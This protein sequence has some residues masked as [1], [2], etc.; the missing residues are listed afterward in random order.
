MKTQTVQF[1]V[2]ADVQ[3]ADKDSA[4]GRAYR[5]A[6]PALEKATVSFNQNTLDFVIQLGDLIDGGQNAQSELQAIAAAY[7]QVNTA[8]YHVLGNHDFAG[9][10]RHAV[11]QTLQM[12]QPYYFFDLKG[13]R[14]V[15]LDTLDYAVQGG[16]PENSQNVKNA[17]DMLDQAR[18]KNADN[19]QPYNGAVGLQQFLWLD[20]I[21][22][23]A[24]ARNMPVIIFGHLPL[25]APGEKHTAWNADKIVA[26]IEKYP[27]V[28]AY[29]AGHNHAGGYTLH[30]GVHYV[31]LEGAVNFAADQGA[32]GIVRVT[33]KKI[34]INGFGA[35]TSRTLRLD[36][37]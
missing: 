22:A 27:C 14:F 10:P 29:F 17:C 6:L 21:V 37:H 4:E 12:Q 26:A 3:Y 34:K 18:L 1:G 2:I 28:K 7:A 20:T 8:K 35:L 25:M 19:A 36:R 11:L 33:A 24:D 13:W 9:L 15:V 30:N 16:W 31:T 5:A 32:W 23:E